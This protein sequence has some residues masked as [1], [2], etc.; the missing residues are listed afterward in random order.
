MATFA[1]EQRFD[2]NESGNAEFVRTVQAE[3]CMTDS[4]SDGTPEYRASLEGTFEAIDDSSNGIFETA[5]LTLRAEA[6]IDRNDDGFP[7]NHS[8]AT[9]DG[10]VLNAI[11][12]QQPDRAELHLV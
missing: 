11:V 3:I 9:V 5:T 8:F 4:A 10:V 12:D 1:G 6:A 7:E 2:R